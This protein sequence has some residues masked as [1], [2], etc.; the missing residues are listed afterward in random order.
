M[1]ADTFIAA[2]AIPLYVVDTKVVLQDH[3][4]IEIRSRRSAVVCRSEVIVQ[5]LHDLH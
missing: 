2:D 3:P 5:T 1:P 4:C